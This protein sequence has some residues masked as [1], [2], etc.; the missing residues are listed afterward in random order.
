MMEHE[1]FSRKSSAAYASKVAIAKELA[2]QGA[3]AVTI[4]AV[5]RTKA[6]D[7]RR[8]VTQVRGVQSPSG[9]TPTSQEYFLSSPRHRQ[10]SAFLLIE[11]QML[12]AGFDGNPDAHGLAFALAYRHYTQ[13]CTREPLISHERMA[14]L[15][16][17]GFSMTWREITRGGSSSFKNQNVKVIGC[18]RCNTPHLAEVHMVRYTCAGCSN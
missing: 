2:E 7:S 18:W 3:R 15:I 1:G 4:T 8:I 9:Q 11:Y 14:L 10:H 13:L 6:V 16:I 17:N 5:A 12:R